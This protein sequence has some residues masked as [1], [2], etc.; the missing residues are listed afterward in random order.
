MSNRH[1]WTYLEWSYGVG[2]TGISD[3]TK[4][5]H[6]DLMEAEASLDLACSALV[7]RE[8]TRRIC[9]AEYAHCEREPVPRHQLDSD[10]I[11]RLLEG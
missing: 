5:K 1:P 4:D 6:Y 8:I 10:N 11:T 3:A 2:N 7:D 9:V